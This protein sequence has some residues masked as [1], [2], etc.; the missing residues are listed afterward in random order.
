MMAEKRYKKLGEVL[1]SQGLITEEQ[2][3]IALRECRR[4]GLSLGAT[5]VQM[6][7]IS[8]D[9][10][11]AVLGEQIHLQQRKRIGE[12]LVEQGFVT[13]D[14]LEKGLAEQRTSK[15]LLGKCLVKLGFISEPKLIDVLSAQLDIQH[16]VLQQFNFS[17][18]LVKCI[19]EDM[20]RRYKVIPLF[21]RNGVL[22]VAMVD[23][24]NLRVIDHL[25]FKTGREIDPV[26]ATEKS[27][28]MAIEKNYASASEEMSQLLSSVA[29][30]GGGDLEVVKSQDEGDSAGG[31]TDEEGAQVVKLVN[32]IVTQAISAGASDIHIEPL[33]S[34]TRLRYRIDGDLVEQSP[35][36]LQMRAQITSRLKIMA[37]MDIAEKRKPQDG[38]FRIRAQGREIDLRVSIFP[39]M[40]RLR[41]VNEKIVM[42]IL[43]PQSMNISIDMLG[44]LPKTKEMFEE[45]IE[46]PDGILLV[47]GPTGSGKS[48]TLYAALKRINDVS[49]NII[50]MEDPVEFNLDGVAQGQINPLAGFTFA[51]G[52]RSILRQDPDVVMIGEMRDAETCQMAIQAALTGHLV[53]STLHTNDSPSAYTRLLDMGIEPFLITSSV[54]GILAQRLVRKLCKCKEQY[55]PDPLLLQ[56]LGLRPG[57]K[58][59]RTKGCKTCNNTGFKGR[60]GLYEFLVPDEEINN[61]VIKRLP[62]EQ[63]KHYALKRGN[64]DSLRRDGLK[65]VLD[66]STTIEQVLSSTQDD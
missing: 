58:F 8:N 9:D 13:A 51:A 1:L 43:D 6:R 16:V 19:P 26:L 49:I 34:Y 7:F 39:V 2:L 62:S 46:K 4:N 38:R 53:F 35:I 18:Q 30:Q 33:E 27:I 64:Y 36:P 10:L 48:S 25:K 60:M 5:L 40:T 44:F 29:S 20:A 28:M 3:L 23:P 15:Q 22:T 12:I 31:L 57:L 32:L 52:M 42:R 41:G 63:I 14:Q 61:M 54:I 37:G 47:T 59:Y 56:R 21:E 65:K 11:T 55:D 17:P 66:G 24:T 50:T 45:V